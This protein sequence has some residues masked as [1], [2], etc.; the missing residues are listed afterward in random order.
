VSGVLVTGGAG[1][2][3]SHVAQA[4]AERGDRV[5]VLD[6]FSS[7]SDE[8]LAG[9]P[10]DV[11]RGDICDPATVE[12]AVSGVRWMVHC[13]AAVSVAESMAD[14][15]RSYEVNVLGTVTLMEAARRAGAM[16][17]VLASSCAVYGDL[18]RP[19]AEEDELRPHSP[20]AES[21]RAMEGVARLYSDGLG[22]P[23]VCLRFFNVYGPR[24]SPH[25]EYAAVIPRF[26][27]ALLAGQPLDI[28][29]DG[30]QSR[31][32]VFVSDVVAACLA[33]AETDTPAGN[34][35]NVGSGRSVTVLDLAQRLQGYF[36][37][38]PAPQHGPARPGDIQ[39]SAA[40]LTRSR[41]AL[42][43]RPRVDLQEGLA[44]TV[45]WLKRRSDAAP[46]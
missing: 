43:Y 7:G 21:K 19:A 30:K 4:L 34:V 15:R 2:I 23:T 10:V 27:A 25:S 41:R 18:G 42:G 40:D 29:G 17:A 12:R 35:F 16:R 36:P 46:S 24:Q 44:A 22:L 31:D 8:N 28:H 14:P 20:Y 33:A 38:A 32:F 3:G 13:A 9:F 5:R 39:S 26:I 1:F 6:D 45:E 37:G 11:I